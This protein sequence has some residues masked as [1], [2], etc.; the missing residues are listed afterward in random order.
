[1]KT[2]NFNKF[3]FSADECKKLKNDYLRMRDCEY[4]FNV[5]DMKKVM[6]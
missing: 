6:Q 2:N 5:E 4:E 1:M 3:I